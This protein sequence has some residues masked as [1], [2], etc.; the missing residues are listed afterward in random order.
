MTDPNDKNEDKSEEGFFMAGFSGASGVPKA[1]V[2]NLVA[3]STAKIETVYNVKL[4][5]LSWTRSLSGMNYADAYASQYT[6]LSANIIE[7]GSL[8]DTD[9]IVPYVSGKKLC[10]MSNTSTFAN[11]TAYLSFQL[12]HL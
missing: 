10:L 1:Y 2:D 12:V 5:S 9:Y 6:I 7:W 11:N 3:Q 4:S 8:R